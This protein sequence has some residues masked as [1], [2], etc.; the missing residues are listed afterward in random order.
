M[1]GEIRNLKTGEYWS[2]DDSC[3]LRIKK[4]DCGVSVELVDQ[5]A[6]IFYEFV[7]DEGK[8]KKFDFGDPI[9]RK[10]RKNGSS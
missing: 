8:T 5:D 9:H 1:K 3:F 2:N 7:I 4:T 6:D 10:G